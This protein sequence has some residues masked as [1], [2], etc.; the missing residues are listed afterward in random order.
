MLKR[1]VP[2]FDRV[3]VQRIQPVK[4]TVGGIVL[5]ETAQE[6]VNE[7]KVVAVGKGNRDAEGKFIPLTVEVGDVVLLPE[8][9]GDDIKLNGESFILIR[10]DDILAKVEQKDQRTPSKKATDLPNISE[11]PKT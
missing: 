4:K 3:L 10:E 7:A 8:F 9:R 6:K 1:V 5:P 11:L 2:L